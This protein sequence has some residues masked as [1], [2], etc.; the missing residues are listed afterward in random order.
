MKDLFTA[1]IA[2]MEILDRKILALSARIDGLQTPLGNDDI[3]RQSA[4]GARQAIDYVYEGLRQELDK[5][6][7]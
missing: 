3:S 5:V 7:D 6:A 2:R 4:D 1:I